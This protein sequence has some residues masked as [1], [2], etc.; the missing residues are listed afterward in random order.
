MERLLAPLHQMNRDFLLY[1]PVDE[2]LISYTS[3]EGERYFIW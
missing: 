1:D 2:I 3:E